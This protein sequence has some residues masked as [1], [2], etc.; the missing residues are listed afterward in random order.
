MRRLLQR[1]ALQRTLELDFYVYILRRSVQIVWVYKAVLLLLL[2][3]AFE[4]PLGA[5]F[6]VGFINDT[7]MIISHLQVTVYNY[8]TIQYHLI[9]DF[10]FND[11][12]SFGDLC[13]NQYCRFRILPNF[14]NL[15]QIG[16]HKNFSFQFNSLAQ[17]VSIFRIQE[18][19]A[20]KNS[21]ILQMSVRCKN[22]Q[23][24]VDYLNKLTEV[25]LEKGIERDDRIA[26]STIQFIDD[27]LKGIT[28][29]L[30]YSEDN[31][32]RFRTTRGVTNID[33]QA[34]QTYEQMEDLQDQQA[35]LIVRSKYYSYLRD[36]LQKNNGK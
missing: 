15:R 22:I 9:T 1:K 33:F 29:S 27:Q 19:E 5:K 24:G 20:T 31:L 16:D 23:Q 2:N 17:L 28:D 25:F 21:S 4:Q 8:Q 3:A 7:L 14:E 18:I 32:Q 36:Y 10:K 12:V 13:G 35:E 26:M 34:Q 30:R 6:N 11:T